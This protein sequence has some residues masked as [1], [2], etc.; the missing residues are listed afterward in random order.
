[1][2]SVRIALC[3]FAL[4]SF[5]LCY[6]QDEKSGG[7]SKSRFVET[8]LLLGQPPISGPM[9]FFNALAVDH[10]GD[11]LVAGAGNWYGLNQFGPEGAVFVFR[12]TGEG[13]FRQVAQLT[14]S[15]AQVNFNFGQVVSVSGDGNTIVAG[16]EA[17]ASYV[18]V[19]PP[20]VWRT[21]TETAKLTASDGQHGDGFGSTTTINYYGDTI[22][23]GAE[24]AT[25][26]NVLYA[27]AIYVF[28]RQGNRWQTTSQ[29]SAK[30][31][32]TAGTFLGYSL[33]LSA[34][35]TT[36]VAGAPGIYGIGAAAYVFVRPEEGWVT[37]TETAKLTASDSVPGDEF[38][39]TLSLDRDGHTAL[40]GAPFGYPAP[41]P[42]AA[43]LFIRPPDGWISMTES[44]KLTSSDGIPGDDFGTVSLTGD[45]RMA[46]IG[47]QAAPFDLTMNLPGPG[48][49]YIFVKPHDGWKT[50]DNYQQKLT[51]PKSAGT[52]A[53]FGEAV[54]FA[55]GKKQRP[56]CRCANGAPAA[57]IWSC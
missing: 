10:D 53:E 29:F 12:R 36:L 35:G 47:A 49:T 55:E 6:A 16:S 1:V 39:L 46:A 52:F 48:A 41:Q 21:M 56:R 51:A 27:G 19:K 28:R 11:T 13:K 26:N 15:D 54:I 20:G 7:H 57:D 24:T 40:V 2:K 14:A 30:L 38:G 32:S 31:T 18:F 25:I 4:I 5:S 37:A 3:I 33:M 22:F 9:G 50:T 43:Y 17:S 8:Q 45:G 34:D 23:I 42:G 44:A